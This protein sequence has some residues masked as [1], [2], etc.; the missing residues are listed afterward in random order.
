MFYPE[1][2]IEEVR[3]ANDIVDVI[4]G[5]VKLQKKGSSYF[6][7]CPFHNEKS[8][9]FSVSPQR[10]MFHCFGCGEG[11]NV[12]H[13]VMEYENYSFQEAVKY[14]ADKAGIALPQVQYSEENRRAADLRGKLLE[15]NKEAAM[16]FVYQLRAP[17]GEKA[18]RYL[19]ERQLPKEVI[20]SFGLGYS[21]MQS[22]DLY[23]YLKDKGY[24][25][26]LLKKSGLFTYAKDKVY[27][28]FFNRVMFPIMDANSK[29]IGFGGR[30][31]GQGEPKYLNSPETDVFDKGK[32]LY[33][34]HVARR[35]RKK[36][37]IICEGYMDV[38]SLH[39]AGFDQ[40]VASL[41]TALTQ[42]QA[43]LMKRY[44]NEVL[45]TYDSD[46]AGRKAALRAIPILQE[47]GL[48]TRVV[49]M[50]P[51][52][53]PDEFIKALG[54]E[55]FQERLDRAMNSFMY[56]IMSLE[57][58]YD[59]KDP[60]DKTRF[61]TEIAKKIVQF[62][63]ELQRSNYIEAVAN[64]YHISAQSLGK[65]VANYGNMQG[66]MSQPVQTA[67]AIHRE[68]DSAKR[69]DG[70]KSAQKILLTWLVNHPEQFET[71]AQYVQPDDFIEPLYHQVATEVFEQLRAGN[72]N[73]A[74]IMNKYSDSDEHNE[75][76]ALFYSE[77]SEKLSLQEQ[78]RALNETVIKVKKNSLDYRS[79]NVKDI[80]ELQNIVK[81]QAALDK[82]NIRLSSF[83]NINI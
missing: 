11:G 44:T 6:G 61:F 15:I 77:L 32:N 80:S 1:D 67:K 83:S 74:G 23:R 29:V 45:I 58:N 47:A 30:V 71:V 48:K 3:S 9:S 79:R 81:E 39:R 75:V 28:K 36:N 49:D 78:E 13:F 50:K 19:Q 65:M 31:M 26:D 4:S 8:P 17:Q 21:N 76:S 35:S 20:N 54:A 60:D 12:I 66:L 62:P 52:K 82:I 73:L 10:Q 34:L 53:D 43:K 72:L 57:E 64:R 59:L 25:D 46:G 68:R 5:C 69:E 70:V 56:E 18:R 27:D 7:L 55:A 63:E 42:G 22:D 14:L 24:S 16:Y 41:G 40:A 38:I 37:F 33:G 2:V 51:Y